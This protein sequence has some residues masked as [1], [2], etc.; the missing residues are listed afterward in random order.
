MAAPSLAVLDNFNRAN[1]NIQAGNANWTS[2]GLYEGAVVVSIVSNVVAGNAGFA[3]AY[4]NAATFGDTEVG[5]TIT[6]LPATNGLVYL[7]ARGQSPGTSGADGYQLVYERLSGT[8]SIRVDRVINQSETTLATRSQ[9]V[10]VG[11]SI[12]LV[13]L[14][15]GATVTL[16]IW[17]RASGGSWSQLGAD[18]SDTNANRITANGRIGFGSNDATA[19][20]D[21]FFGG[22]QVSAQNLTLPSITDSDTLYTPTISADGTAIS[23][24]Y[25]TDSDTLYTPTVLLTQL[26]TLPHITTTADQAARF[27]GTADNREDRIIIP[28]TQSS[29]TQSTA[30]NVGASVF[31]YDV[32]IKCRYADNPTTATDARYS[33]II[34]DRDIWNDNRGHVPLGVTRNGSDLVIITGFNVSGTW[35]SQ[36]GTIHVG[37]SAWHHIAIDRNGSTLRV[38]VD[39][40]LDATLTISSG[41]YAYPTSYTPTGGQDNEYLVIGAEKHDFNPGVNGYTGQVNELRISNVRRYTGLSFTSPTAPFDVDSD[42]VGLYHLNGDANDSTA[43]AVHGTL[44]TG[45]T[46]EPST[47]FLGGALYAPNLTVGAAA[48]TLPFI[49]SSAVLTS[50][51]LHLSVTLPLITDSDT[52][53]VPAVGYVTTIPY[54][55]T[56]ATLYAPQIVQTVDL[57]YLSAGGSLSTPVII[58]GAVGI[59]LPA[60]SESVLYAPTIVAGSTALTLPFLTSTQA[61]YTP[62]IIPGSVTLAVP[63]QSSAV[64]LYALQLSGQDTVSL[65]FLSAG[66]TLFLPELSQTTVLP[67][68]ASSEILYSP[69]LTAGTITTAP[70]LSSSATIY[71]PSVV[72]GSVSVALPYLQET[73]VSIPSVAYRIDTP[74]LTNVSAFY[75]PTLTAGSVA[76]TIPHLSATTL[77]LF[78]ITGGAVE[79][80]PVYLPTSLLPSGALLGM[81]NIAQQFMTQRCTIYHPTTTYNAYGQSV[82][83]SGTGVVVSG[84]HGGLRGADRELLQYALGDLRRR[85]GVE[86]KTSAIFLFP[87]GTTVNNNS[88][89]RANDKDWYVV[90]NSRDTQ[91]SVRV[92]EKVIA[93]QWEVRDESSWRQ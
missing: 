15:S 83:I 88:V 81:Q 51:S 69:E 2:P 71:A 13:V 74:F 82:V 54:L 10:S 30:V 8:D 29:G 45:A 76:I 60:L 16:Q 32:W 33:N 42:T 80:P 59:T 28:L 14:G 5:I 19:R 79:N 21:D 84:Y 85:S 11:D 48:I 27:Y 25:I 55:A 63:Y 35:A 90:W 61:F 78:S 52:L 62:E 50:P 73:V 17:Y 87:I 86:V 47:L 26:V 9:E 18:I 66:V 57:P 4:W 23:L 43:N 91:A 89:V 22:T 34:L 6:T 70:F 38:F 3:E 24:P 53:Y 67:F 58:P 40:V 37:D 36:R 1:G 7:W 92:Y 31:T 72:P 68:I 20:M 41:S 77:Y 44:L 64:S 39:G 75:T 56:N 93:V 46:W 12:A 49:S 65:P